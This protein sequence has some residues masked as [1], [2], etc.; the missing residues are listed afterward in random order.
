MCDD[1]SVPILIIIGVGIGVE[2][3][4]K[5]FKSILSESVEE[6]THFPIIAEGIELRRP[7]KVF[8]FF[9]KVKFQLDERSK[10][11]VVYHWNDIY[12]V[13][14]EAI[15]PRTKLISWLGFGVKWLV[16]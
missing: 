16:M 15:V 7:T 11:R 13:I 4:M 14:L 3:E 9:E 6:L 5:E 1:D 8:F 2:Y 10:A 12:F